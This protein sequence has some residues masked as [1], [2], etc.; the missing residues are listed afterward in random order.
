MFET[1]LAQQTRISTRVAVQERHTHRP[2]GRGLEHAS[3]SRYR[4]AYAACMHLP[5][6]LGTA[7]MKYIRTGTVLQLPGEGPRARF[8]FSKSLCGCHETYKDHNRALTA[9][10]GPRA[11]FVPLLDSDITLSDLRLEGIKQGLGGTVLR[12]PAHPDAS[13]AS[14]TLPLLDITAL[15]QL[16]CIQSTDAPWSLAF[17]I[18]EARRC[19]RSGR[20]IRSCF[21]V[22]NQPRT[23]DPDTRDRG[24]PAGQGRLIED[25]PGDNS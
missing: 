9:R 23:T 15:A 4:S 6:L 8:R 3:A 5:S 19:I 11:R 10:Q 22:S 2:A 12:L 13:R 16:P 17:Q 14:S 18:P 1:A 21:L 20:G 24:R 25:E 7:C